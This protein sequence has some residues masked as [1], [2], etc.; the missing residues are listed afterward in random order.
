MARI[1]TV[2]GRDI[3]KS[4]E[5]DTS[6]NVQLI[7]PDAVTGQEAMRVI[8]RMRRDVLRQEK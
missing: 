6:D 2:T 3:T 1:Y 7:I 8:E 4:I 5:A